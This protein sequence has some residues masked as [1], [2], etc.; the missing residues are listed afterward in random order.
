MDVD[1]ILAR[2]PG[3]VL[4]DE[5]AHSNIEGRGKHTKRF[6]DLMDLL[7]ARIDVLSL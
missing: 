2:K 1:A 6:E 3:V 5:L 4:V 7:E